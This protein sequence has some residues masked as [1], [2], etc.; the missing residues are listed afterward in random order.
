MYKI[1]STSRQSVKRAALFL[2]KLLVRYIIY[3]NVIDGHL[4]VH[5]KLFTHASQGDN[6]QLTII[7]IMITE[8]NK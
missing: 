7:Y 2:L 1:I 8:L 6:S 3:I 4:K 5:F